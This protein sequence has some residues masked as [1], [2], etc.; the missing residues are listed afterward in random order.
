[1]VSGGSEFMPCCALAACI[2]G[3]LIL[4]FG[5]IKTL[6]LGSS[7]QAVPSNPAVEWRLD[8]RAVTVAAAPAAAWLP[9]R[10][11][12]GLVLAAVL[13]VVIV[14]GALYG[15]A[16]HR[17]HGRDARHRGHHLAHD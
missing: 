1:M 3:Q 15:V 10:F 17:G 7:K 5:A 6:L 4:A 2:V 9:N 8:E 16:E 12:R 13:E 11:R 14:L